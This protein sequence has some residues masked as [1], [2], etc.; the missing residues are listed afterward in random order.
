MVTVT[1]VLTL[2]W[3]RWGPVIIRRLIAILFSFLLLLSFM[4]KCCLKSH[5]YVRNSLLFRLGEQAT[6]TT[7]YRR[8]IYILQILGIHD[9]RYIYIYIY[10]YIYMI[11]K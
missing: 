9:S 11:D 6:S 1:H 10:I 8:L 2:Q 7:V 3:F 5:S 4:S